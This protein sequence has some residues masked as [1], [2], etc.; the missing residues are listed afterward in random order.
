VSGST[1]DA[2]EIAEMIKNNVTDID[3]IY[4]TLDTHHVL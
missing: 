3:E 1:Q 2:K 4:I